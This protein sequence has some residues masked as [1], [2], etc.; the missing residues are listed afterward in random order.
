M[1]GGHEQIAVEELNEH[2]HLPSLKPKKR[3]RAAVNWEAIE[4]DVCAIGGFPRLREGQLD[5]A[6]KLVAGWNVGLI[7]PTAWGKSM[8]WVLLA[9]AAIQS[10]TKKLV[11]VISPTKAL[12]TDIVSTKSPV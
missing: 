5:L 2:L 3:L 1:E 7:A 8:L 6:K 12:Q 9:K 10:G 11:V 4:A